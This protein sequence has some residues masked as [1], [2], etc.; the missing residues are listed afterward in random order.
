MF[1]HGGHGSEVVQAPPLDTLSQ[2]SLVQLLEVRAC[3]RIFHVRL[4]RLTIGQV[5][6]EIGWVLYEMPKA[7]VWLR[8]LQD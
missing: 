4:A 2:T 3:I 8:C 7:K 1:V 5:S 6:Q